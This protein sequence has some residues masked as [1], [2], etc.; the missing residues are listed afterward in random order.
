MFFF[1]GFLSKH[2]GLVI[3]HLGVR[4]SMIEVSCNLHVTIHYTNSFCFKSKTLWSMLLCDPFDVTSTASTVLYHI[5]SPCKV[6]QE[7]RTVECKMLFSF[8][9]PRYC[10]FFIFSK[11]SPVFPITYLL[12]G[13]FFFS[14]ELLCTV[15]ALCTFC[16]LPKTPLFFFGSYICHRKRK[17]GRHCKIFCVLLTHAQGGLSLSSVTVWLNGSLP[18][19]KK[20]KERNPAI[21]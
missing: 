12:R 18:F 16:S 5:V 21:A 14:P 11:L 7:P 15:S 4:S 10:I 6:K 1:T 19:K 20:K 2:S 17:G 13:G 3:P 8:G 9:Q